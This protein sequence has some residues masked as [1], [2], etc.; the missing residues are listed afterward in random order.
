MEEYE[1]IEEFILA[2][3]QEYPQLDMKF[4][5]NETTET[6]D[7]IFDTTE[8]DYP[9]KEVEEVLYDFADSMLTGENVFN[10]FLCH[11]L[12]FSKK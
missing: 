7:I 4:D 2:V 5:Y 9:R 11:E 3:Q 12:T 1:L 6:Y 10:F 8:C